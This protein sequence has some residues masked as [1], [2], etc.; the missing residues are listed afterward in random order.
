MLRARA[1][2]DRLSSADD[3]QQ[4]DDDGNDQQNVDQSAGS[5]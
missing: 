5:Q 2:S 1:L 4:N 3:A